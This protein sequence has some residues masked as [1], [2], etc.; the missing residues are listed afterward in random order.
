[1]AHFW[2]TPLMSIE[3][4][5]LGAERFKCEPELE[6][7]ELR[8][9]LD[10]VHPWLLPLFKAN[11][12]L[13]DEETE[14]CGNDN[15][16]LTLSLAEA[17]DIVF[18]GQPFVLSHCADNFLERILTIEQT[19]HLLLAVRNTVNELWTPA[20]KQWLRRIEEW[21]AARCEVIIVREEEY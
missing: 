21:N 1:M 12:L 11:L 2:L 15:E 14:S 7:A 5:V 4:L 18:D 8:Q 20:Q 16:E 17:E 3:P 19:E 9:K 13:A 6:L 10:A